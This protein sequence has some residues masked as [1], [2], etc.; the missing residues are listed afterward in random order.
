MASSS[1]NEIAE[2]SY[3]SGDNF[4]CGLGAGGLPPQ[5]TTPTP[6]GLKGFTYE[7]RNHSYSTTM[8]SA[9]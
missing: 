2:V 1:A 4:I 8:I 6:L 5:F 7:T 3:S 9:V